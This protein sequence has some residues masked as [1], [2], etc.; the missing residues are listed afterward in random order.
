MYLFLASHILFVYVY[1]QW[2]L[3]INVY[4]VQ[5]KKPAVEF[6]ISLK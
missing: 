6:T 3:F 1:L 2:I 4:K 5:I